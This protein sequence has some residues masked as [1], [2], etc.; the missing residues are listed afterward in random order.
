MLPLLDISEV[1]SLNLS[2]AGKEEY[3][4]FGLIE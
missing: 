3:R 1:A 2:V 4:N